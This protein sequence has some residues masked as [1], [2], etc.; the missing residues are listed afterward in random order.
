MSELPPYEKTRP[1]TLSVASYDRIDHWIKTLRLIYCMAG[2]QADHVGEIPP[3]EL[4]SLAHLL[5]EDLKA[6]QQDID[7]DDSD[8]GHRELVAWLRRDPDGD[9]EFSAP[10]HGFPVYRAPKRSRDGAIAE[11]S[12]VKND[13]GK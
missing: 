7:S 2:G 1:Y 9:L 6:I 8:E 13:E 4:A 10:G 11:E 3:E 12:E 5:F